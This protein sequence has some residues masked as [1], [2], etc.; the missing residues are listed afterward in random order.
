MTE[1]R[2]SHHSQRL[3]VQRLDFRCLPGCRFGLGQPTALVQLR[4]TGRVTGLAARLDRLHALAPSMMPDEPLYLTPPA[5]WPGALLAEGGGEHGKPLIR[6]AEWFTAAAILMQRYARQPVGG[7]RV[8]EASPAGITFAVPWYRRDV[9]KEALGHAVR[10]VLMGLATPA[11]RLAAAHARWQTGLIAW[12]DRVRP[13]QMGLNT[14]RFALA[15]LKA[16][17]PVAPIAQDTLQI[18]WGRHSRWIESSMNDATGGIAMRMAR[19]KWQTGQRLEALGLPVPR[20]LVARTLEELDAA[21]EAFGYPL[22]V[23]P[24]NQDAA[25]GVTVNI[26]QRDALVTAFEAALKLSPGGALIQ[27]FMSGTDHRLLVVNGECLMVSKRHPAGVVGDGEQSVR[28]LIEAANENPLR[29]TRKHSTLKKITLD[30]D[31]HRWLAEQ[32]LTLDSVPAAGQRVRLRSIP[33]MTTGGVHE[34]VTAQVHPDNKA[35][36]VAAAKAVRLNVAGIDMLCPDIRRSWREVGATIIEVNG[37]PNVSLHWTFSPEADIYGQM[38]SRL[39]LPG[40]GRVPLCLDLSGQAATALA[41][42]WEQRRA[43]KDGP[44]TLIADG[45]NSW[46]RVQRAMTDPDLAALWIS[47]AWQ[48]VARQGLPADGFDL[49]LLSAPA[50]TLTAEHL[51]LLEEI[52]ARTRRGLLLDAALRDTL[53]PALEG[54]QGVVELVEPKSDTAPGAWPAALATLLDRLD[55]QR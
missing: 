36:A 21:A 41:N 7:G 23:K 31:S 27:P 9:L 32:N 6:L 30:D 4:L 11:P 14:Q 16:G 19:H 45:D 43:E 25:E 28:A 2:D 46:Q 13:T 39:A 24:A 15:A 33:N 26:R 29:G 35:L 40:T 34:N 18:G 20:T 5:Q 47:T 48:E 44:V 10:W 49:T 42:H 8:V 1:R 17:Y 53:G 12:L 37:Q 3:G 50:E 55:T 22:V 52:V 38:L 54:F 51:A